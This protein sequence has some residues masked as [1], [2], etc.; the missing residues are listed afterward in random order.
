MGSTVEISLIE[1]STM[2]PSNW[3]PFFQLLKNE[4]SITPHYFYVKPRG[5]KI[6]SFCILGFIS[7]RYPTNSESQIVGL[8]QIKEGMPI[9]D[10]LP[11]FVNGLLWASL[12]LFGC[13]YRGI[14]T[15][16]QEFSAENS[17]ELVPRPNASGG[18]HLS[19]GAIPH[20]GFD[21]LK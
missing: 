2:L 18:E 1:P 19:R 6:A 20:G 3:F 4:V 9:A 10:Q 7:S 14:E 12:L 11:H 16:E 17:C 21:I 15:A 5:A 8:Q 13:L